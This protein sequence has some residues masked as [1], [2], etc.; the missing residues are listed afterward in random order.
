MEH[1]GI[2]ANLIEPTDWVI[3][4]V[5]V[6]K[7]LSGALRIWLNLHNLNK[8]LKRPHYPL[9]TQDDVISRL[10]GARYFSVLDAR[11]GYWAIKLTE[12]SSKLTTFNMVVRWYLFLHLPFR[13]ISA[14]DEFQRKISETYETYSLPPHL[15]RMCLQLQKYD[16]TLIHRP[17]KEIPVADTLSRKY[18][19]TM[20]HN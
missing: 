4:L 11:L 16:F 20:T 18:G 14:Q 13:I 15:Q 10:S 3:A 8:V 6:E 5:V 17:G 9:P 19:A 2:I 1:Q 12:K 7:P